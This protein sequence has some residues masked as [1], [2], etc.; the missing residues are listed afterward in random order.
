M[1]TIH[2]IYSKWTLAL[3][4][5][6]TLSL[7]AA[8]DDD[9]HK[10]VTQ[11]VATE[12]SPLTGGRNT[13]LTLNGSHFGTD[14][15]QVKVTING[16]ET[17]VKSVADDK[18][19]AEVQ[20]GTSS[21]LVRIIL[22]ERPNA[23]VLIYD[24]EFTYISNQVVSTY[25]GGKG[26]GEADGPFAEAT[27][28]KPRYLVWGK[29]NALYIV[30]DGASSPTDMACIRKAKDGQLTTLL[31]AADSPLVQ[32]MRGI[33]FSADMGTLYI[34]ND[35]NKDGS[36]GFGTMSKSGED[37]GNLTAL[38]EQSGI[39]AIS[40][41]PSTGAI[42]LGY[43]TGAWIYQYDGTTF[44]PKAQLPGAS[45]GTFADKGNINSIVFDKA[46]TTVYIVSRAKHVIYKGHYD[47]ASGSFSDL[48]LLA[49]SYGTTGYADGT[50]T[51]AK[52]NTPC[53]ADIDEEGNLY[54][55]DR[56]NHCIRAVT[57]DGEVSTYAGKNVA[58]MVDGIASQAEFNNPE[59]CRF[60]PDGALYIA[61]Y[62][63]H[64]IRKVE[65]VSVQ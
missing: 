30:E 63:N 58:G 31:K 62:S 23:Q 39:T 28:S 1:K 13:L 33:G 3:A 41:H 44:I 16:K 42:F 37:Y 50:G 51:A 25:L 47:L 14:P 4:A 27:L 15:T 53:Q 7:L 49:G 26:S 21:G 17:V 60:G 55:A 56:G 35:T 19:T 8:C 59:G 34:A 24:A 43:H 12:Y 6:M 32:R 64:A 54:V 46:G 57:P 10:Q 65:E 20:K 36:M 18:I 40:V 61:D 22:G 45:D 5:V 38:W 11:A 52:F 9:G 48:Q 2:S 29:D